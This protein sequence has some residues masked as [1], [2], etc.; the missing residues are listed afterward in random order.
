MAWEVRPSRA[1]PSRAEVRG[2]VAGMARRA[3]GPAAGR[4]GGSH[5]AQRSYSKLSLGVILLLHLTPAPLQFSNVLALQSSENSHGPTAR[6]RGVTTVRP[7]LMACR[8]SLLPLTNHPADSRAKIPSR[9][10]EL[11][12]EWLGDMSSRISTPSL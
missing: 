7:F 2:A 5:I 3:V 11:L 6:H 8:Y 9:E 1:E 10:L 12:A 4:I